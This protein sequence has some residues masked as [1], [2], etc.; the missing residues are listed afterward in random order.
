MQNSETILNPTSPDADKR[1]AQVA[2]LHKGHQDVSHREL[3]GGDFWRRVPAYAHIDEATFCDHNWQLKNSI[4]SVKKLLESLK[5]FVAPEFYR[6]VEAG[7]HHA[8]MAVRVSPYVMA[9]IDWTNA[10]EDPL[11]RQFIPLKSRL[12]PDHPELMLDSL[13]EQADSPV[14]GFTHR[15]HD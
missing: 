8:P 13:H 9:L 12:E 15:Y 7:F 11:R 5:D 10:Y 3:V 2:L 6:D 4:T 1:R 14:E